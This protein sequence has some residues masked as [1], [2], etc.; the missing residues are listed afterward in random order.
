MSQKVD[1]LPIPPARIVAPDLGYDKVPNLSSMSSVGRRWWETVVV[2]AVVAETEPL[3]LKPMTPSTPGC[4]HDFVGE[5]PSADLYDLGMM[6]S[7]RN[8]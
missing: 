3:Q 7:K 2:D 8:L 6:G 1:G 5:L 4:D